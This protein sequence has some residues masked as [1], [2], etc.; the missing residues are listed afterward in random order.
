MPERGQ[1]C[2]Q[3]DPKT[4][5]APMFHRRSDP[6]RR[7][8]RAR[9]KFDKGLSIVF[10]GQERNDLRQSS[11]A[12][13]GARGT[14]LSSEALLAS[15][16]TALTFSGEASLARVEVVG[17]GAAINALTADALKLRLA[18]EDS[19]AH[20]LASGATLTPAPRTRC[21]PALPGPAKR[22]H[23]RAPW[24]HACEPQ[25]Q[26]R[27]VVSGR[28]DPARSRQE[29]QYAAV[30]VNILTAD[31]VGDVRRTTNSRCFAGRRTGTRVGARAARERQ[32]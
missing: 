32:S 22:S 28:S 9:G 21:A 1:P 29:F 30:G 31:G 5:D 26:L 17:N 14:V 11:F 23:R 27:G 7:Q 3:P 18:L 25:R 2:F 10:Q 8:R 13:D 6:G 15:G 12:A 24:P 20:T 19:H 4:A 16:R